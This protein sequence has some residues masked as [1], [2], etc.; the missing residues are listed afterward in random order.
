VRRE[1]VAFAR[2]R[3][4]PLVSAFTDVLA[5]HAVVDPRRPSILPGR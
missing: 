5:E 4:S 1:L 2:A 3:P